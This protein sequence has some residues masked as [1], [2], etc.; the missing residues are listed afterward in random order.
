MSH[1]VRRQSG[2]GQQGGE[3]VRRENR[4]REGP[5]GQTSAG[6]LD[7]DYSGPGLRISQ[8]QIGPSSGSTSSPTFVIPHR[9]RTVVEALTSASVWAI[10]TS[11][12]RPNAVSINQRAAADVYETGLGFH[13]GQTCGVHQALGTGCNRSGKDDVVGLGEQLIEL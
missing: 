2:V 7:G 9:C 3:E 12:P 4:V 1:E 10:T 5:E 6:W 11:T 8:R 13:P